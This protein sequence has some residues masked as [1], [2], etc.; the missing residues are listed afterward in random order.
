MLNFC[1]K[2]ENFIK[3]VISGS[4]LY[5]WEIGCSDFTLNEWVYSLYPFS[6][7]PSYSGQHGREFRSSFLPLCIAF[8]ILCLKRQI[9]LGEPSGNCNHRMKGLIPVLLD[10]NVQGQE[11]NEREP[12]MPK[13]SDLWC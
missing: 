12:R 11:K 6:H 9:E 3:S 4:C 1:S 10:Q 8:A 7:K 5:S 13:L 2:N